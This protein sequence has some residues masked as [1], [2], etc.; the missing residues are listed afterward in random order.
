MGIQ[1]PQN[2][3]KELNG[4]FLRPVPSITLTFPS[5][6]QEYEVRA[7]LFCPSSLA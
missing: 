4:A 6:L 7:A 2:F 3:D 5:N 1:T